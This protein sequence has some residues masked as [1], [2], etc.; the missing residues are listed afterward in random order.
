VRGY[1]ARYADFSLFGSATGLRFLGF[2]LGRGLI[3]N[4]TNLCTWAV[5]AWYVS[6]GVCS[7]GLFLASLSWSSH[8]TS[9]LSSALDI[10]KQWLETMLAIR[11]YFTE[12]DSFRRTAEEQPEED[13]AAVLA[14]VVVL[15]SELRVLVLERLAPWLNSATP[16][17]LRAWVR[18]TGND[19]RRTRPQ[20]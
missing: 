6:T 5:G 19:I 8:L 16:L 14:G 12:I 13:E 17:V 7:L 10:Q 18:R 4:L 2:N 20:L 11:P 15:A 3:V 1:H 9:M